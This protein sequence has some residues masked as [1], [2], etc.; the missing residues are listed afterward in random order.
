MVLAYLASKVD[1]PLLLLLIV[2]SLG[3]T[4][5]ALTTYG[6]GVLAARKYPLHSRLSVRHQKGV[7]RVDHYGPWA[8]LFSWLPI[9]GDALCF[10]AGWLRLHFLLSLLAITVGKVMRYSLVIYLSAP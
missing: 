2:A 5:G 10:A 7:E 1:A 6:L 8:L 9:V 4:L 3:N